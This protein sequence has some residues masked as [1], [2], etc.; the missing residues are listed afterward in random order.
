MSRLQQ[1]HQYIATGSCMRFQRFILRAGSR[2]P[3]CIVLLQYHP[4]LCFPVPCLQEYIKGLC[5]PELRKEVHYPQDMHC[6]FLGAQSLFLDCLIQGTSASLT[7]LRSG[8]LLISGLAEAFVMAESRIQEF[9]AKYQKNPKLE[10]EQEARVKRAFRELV[11]AYD[12]KHAMDLLILPTSVKEDLLSLVKET[13]GQRL[14]NGCCIPEG[15]GQDH[16]RPQDISDVPVGLSRVREQGRRGDCGIDLPEG[17]A[18][19][20]EAH[21]IQ[22]SAHPEY[23]ARPRPFRTDSPTLGGGPQDQIRPHISRIDLLRGLAKSEA[24]TSPPDSPAGLNGLQGWPEAAATPGPM[25][26]ESALN[27]IPA[28]R[29]THNTPLFP[30][31]PGLMESLEDRQEERKQV[32]E[33]S[34]VS[35][36]E[37][38]SEEEE[39]SSDFLLSSW[40]EKEFK[41]RLDFFKTMGYEERV[42]KKVLLEGGMR[43]APSTILDRVQMEEAGLSQKDDPL[44]PKELGKRGVTPPPLEKIQGES[45]YLM[46][47]IKAAVANCGHS[48][49]EILP[50]LQTGAP[51]AGLLRRLNRKG[52]CNDEAQRV[53]AASATKSAH[54]G[55][56][57]SQVGAIL[58]QEESAQHRHPQETRRNGGSPFLEVARVPPLDPPAAVLPPD[59]TPKANRLLT[60]W[61]SVASQSAGS[62]NPAPPSN[63]PVST[64]TGAQRFEEALQTQFKLKLANVPG[65]KNLRRVII[66]GSNLAMM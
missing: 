9:V 5:A 34:P 13:R 60:T 63:A 33:L 27:R 62:T 28:G 58:N 49:S 44:P 3:A 30:G 19:L 66:D 11:E 50:E 14:R 17:V 42:V 25:H 38:S 29:T 52:E 55:Q 23:S 54:G 15:C 47:V 46:E 16:G 1:T 35:L 65:K 21:K 57:G 41:M 61:D 36:P 10:E 6:I 18:R 37:E 7:L 22:D 24:N 39:P 43:D 32:R 48:P 31:N 56:H 45:D 20:Q 51:L 4:L 40:T 12:D 26:P 59:R 2:A 53:M 64:V 8:S